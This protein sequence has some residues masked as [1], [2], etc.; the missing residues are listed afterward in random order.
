M[1]CVATVGVVGQ[2]AVPTS[3]DWDS[4]RLAWGQ[5]FDSKEVIDMRRWMFATGLGGDE[6]RVCVAV[7]L[8]DEHSNTSP[9]TTGQRATRGHQVTVVL[10]GDL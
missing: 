6:P 7:L 4:R 1:C 8:S 5:I 10:V 2:V 9:R 3:A